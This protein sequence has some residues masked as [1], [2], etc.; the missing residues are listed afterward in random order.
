[1]IK[2]VCSPIKDG[3]INAGDLKILNSMVDAVREG[4]LPK[5]FVNALDDVAAAGDK[6][7]ADTQARL[8][9]ACDSATR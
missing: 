5:E 8:V 7:P 9:A 4:G 1:M 6:V 2:T 3:T